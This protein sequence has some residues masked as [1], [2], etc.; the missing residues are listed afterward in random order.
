MI[1][2]AMLS[3]QWRQAQAEWR[4][5]LRLRLAAWLVLAIVLAYVLRFAD[6]LRAELGET[7]AETARYHGQ[8]ERIVGQPQWPQ[9][10]Q[11]AEAEA[12]AMEARLWRADSLGL[13]QASFQSWL[14]GQ[15]QPFAI[16]G[17]LTQVEPATVVQAKPDF[18][19]VPAQVRGEFEPDRFLRLLRALEGSERLVSVERLEIFPI[20][21][22]KRGFT[23]VLKAWFQRPSAKGAK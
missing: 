12:H 15:L 13:A 21:Q 2:K 11:Q 9:R 18:W 1:D 10:A 23:L 4:D 17:L 7:L 6:V 16:A 8:I 3:A 19:Q 14:E 22:D 20:A 5:N